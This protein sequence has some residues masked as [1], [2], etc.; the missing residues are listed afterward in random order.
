M[1]VMASMNETCFN[2]CRAAVCSSAVRIPVLDTA[3]DLVVSIC[4]LLIRIVEMQA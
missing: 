4:I 3:I 1:T 2:C